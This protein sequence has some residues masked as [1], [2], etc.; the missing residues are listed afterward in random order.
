MMNELLKKAL[1]Q[2]GAFVLAIQP[3]SVSAGTIP[4]SVEHQLDTRSG[5]GLHKVWLHENGNSYWYENGV[6]QGVYGDPKN[7]RDTIYGVERGREIYDPGSNAW[8]WLDANNNGAMARNKDVWLP[9]VFQNE[10]P[11]SS[12]GKW[13]RYDNNGSMLKGIQYS[14]KYK[15]WYYFDVTTGAMA[16][17]WRKSSTGGWAYY[18]LKSGK[19]KESDFQ[20]NGILYKPM[21]NGSIGSTIHANVPYYNQRDK[22]WSSYTL[23][24]KSLGQS[25][26]AV[27][28][29]TTILN[30]FAKRNV[31]PP[32]V[33][34]LFHYWGDYN[35]AYGHGTDN[36]VWRKVAKKYNLSFKN[37]MSIADVTEAL[38][39]GNMIVANVSSGNFVAYPDTHA[40]LLFNIDPRGR[41]YVYDPFNANNNGWY[42][43]T[44]VYRQGSSASIDLIDGGPF[45]SLGY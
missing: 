21:A 20:L 18:D 26:C 45:I 33:A 40:I 14:S 42:D 9:Y 31:T 29:G 32:D 10:R 30:Y 23:G 4:G 6:R 27:C 43:V 5:A 15:A 16:K 25:G 11:G 37:N 41:T 2:L 12:E 36:G 7:I 38:T 28:V 24:S 34:D 8:Y 13:V 44:D 3:L 17:G 22:R 19:L 39:K 35:G 1:V